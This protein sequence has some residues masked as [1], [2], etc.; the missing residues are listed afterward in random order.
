MFVIMTVLT[1]LKVPFEKAAP[2]CPS[3][4]P[5]PLNGSTV[6]AAVKLVVK[7]TH[8]SEKQQL[9]TLSKSLN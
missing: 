5:A 1:I 7:K 2:P 8:L 4:V 9:I 6:E 3:D